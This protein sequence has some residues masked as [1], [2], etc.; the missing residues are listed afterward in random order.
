[1]CNSN[2]TDSNCTPPTPEPFPIYCNSS[3]DSN[4]TPPNNTILVDNSSVNIDPEVLKLFNLT[5]EDLKELTKLKEF[6]ENLGPS[7]NEDWCLDWYPDNYINDTCSEVYD[8][9]KENVEIFKKYVKEMEEEKDDEDES[10]NDDEEDEIQKNTTDKNSTIFE[11]MRKKIPRTNGINIKYDN[12]EF[13][14]SMSDDYK[15]YEMRLK[16]FDYFDWALV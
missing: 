3:T 13:K 6:T 5:M 14:V 16:F 12:F 9:F 10:E 2:S 15:F 11:K 8:E 1:L 4:C 7:D